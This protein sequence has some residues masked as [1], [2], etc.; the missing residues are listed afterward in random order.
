MNYNEYKN[1]TIK[2]PN[3]IKNI[4]YRYT[5]NNSTLDLNIILSNSKTTEDTCKNLLKSKKFMIFDN[6]RKFFEPFRSSLQ[7]IFRRAF[8]A[9]IEFRRHFRFLKFRIFEDKFF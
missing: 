8:E 2:V 4:L 1:Y 7:K 9:H 6:F 3:I 5:N